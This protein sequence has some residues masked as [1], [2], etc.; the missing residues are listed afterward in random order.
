MLNQILRLSKKKK[1]KR[2]QSN[3]WTLYLCLLLDPL[4]S[5]SKVRRKL[6]VLFTTASSVSFVH[7]KRH[8]LSSDSY[9]YLQNLSLSCII[10]L[11]FLVPT[12]E[13][14]YD[15]KNKVVINIQEFNGGEGYHNEVQCSTPMGTIRV[16]NFTREMR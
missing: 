16:S 3:W 1:K 11:A 5:Y 7:L 10:I 6:F 14:I 9:L 13:T 15:G 12:L 8:D 2:K 4:S